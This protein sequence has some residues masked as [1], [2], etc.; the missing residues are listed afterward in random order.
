[1]AKYIDCGTYPFIALDGRRFVHFIDSMSNADML[2][3]NEL[4]IASIEIN[5]HVK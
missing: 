5:G 2:E 3:R 1:M 4:S